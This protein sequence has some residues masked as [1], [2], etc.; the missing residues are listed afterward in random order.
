MLT[1]LGAAF[2]RE[3][4]LQPPGANGGAPVLLHEEPPGLEGHLPQPR[5]QPALL[6][7]L[8]AAE[9]PELRQRTVKALL[10][11]L[12]FEWLGYGCFSQAGERPVPRSFCTTYADPAWT[13]RYFAESY[14]LVDPRLPR[15]PESGLPTLWTLEELEAEA[16]T[17]SYLQGLRQRFFDDL[18][19][20]GARSGVM[21]GLPSLPGRDRH[22]VSLISK[23]PCCD[24]MSDAVLGQVLT[25][26][27]CLH[28]FYSRYTL[29]P[30]ADGPRHATGT[31]TPLQSEI[32]ARLARGLPDKLIAAQLDLSLHNVDYHMRQL[33][34]RFGVRNRLQL[35]Q[36]ALGPAPHVA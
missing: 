5:L 16:G 20:T 26:A 31:L 10:Q 8:M 22:I 23:R 25:L 36:A 29:A 7:A 3:D 18:R 35:M 13:E 33:R 30:Q 2:R 34:K 32:L 6:V 14:H 11:S 28:E 21:M 27:L 24:W 4:Y 19:A 1:S 15:V 12:G 17:P 9:T